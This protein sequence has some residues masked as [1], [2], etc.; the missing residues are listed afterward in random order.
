MRTVA[1]AFSDTGLRENSVHQ[2]SVRA[3]YSD[4]TLSAP[5]ATITQRMDRPS[6]RSVVTDPQLGAVGDGTTLNTRAIQK[7]IDDGNTPRCRVV[8]PAGTFL[9]GALFSTAAR[10]STSPPVPGSWA[11]TGGRTTRSTRATTSIRSRTPYPPRPATP[12]TSSPRSLINVLPRD[13]GRNRVRDATH[14]LQREQR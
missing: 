1:H 6:Q 11:P 3:V 13:N 7:A 5:S 8:I 4:G 9:T 14:H 2:F 12:A 10:R